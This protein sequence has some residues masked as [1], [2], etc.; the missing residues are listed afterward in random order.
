MSEAATTRWTRR[1][2]GCAALTVAAFVQAPRWTSADT[3]LDLLVDPTRFLGRALTLWEPLGAFGQLQNQAYGYL[4]PMGPFFALGHLLGLPVWVVQR[5]WWACLLVTAFLGLVLLAER[6]D[7]G[8]EGSRILAGLAFALSPRVLTELGGIS[9]ELW[10]TAVAPWVVLPLIGVPPGAERRAAARSGLAVALAGGVNAIAAGAV[11]PLAV[12]W[13]AQV[14]RGRARRRLATW[15][16]L[17]AAAGIGWWLGPLVLLGRYSPPFLDWIESAAVTTS[18]AGPGNALRGVSHWVGWLRGSAAVWPA[19]SQVAGSP[20]LIVLGWCVVALGLAAFFHR[21]TP[22]RTFLVGG[23]VI[24]LA[25]LTMGHVQPGGAPWAGLIRDLLDGPGA[26]L[27]NTHK[28]DVL[29]RL[30][31]SL[32]LAHTVA[33]V[34]LRPPRW[35]PWSRH[36]VR[37]VAISGVLGCAAPVLAGNLAARSPF[38]EI[39]PYWRQAAA[40][41]TAHDDGGRTLVLPGSSF[42]TNYWGDT[43]DEPLQALATTPWAARTVVPLSEPGAIRMLTTV[44]AQLATGRPSPGLADYLARAGISRLLVRADLAGNNGPPIRPLT[45]RS[46]LS[47]SP[48]LLPIARFGP[49]IG[50]ARLGTAVVDSGLDLATPAIEIWQVVGTRAAAEVWPA[51]AVAR[52]AGGVE[53]LLALA[54]AGALHRRPTVLDGDPLAGPLASGPVIVTDGPQRREADFSRVREVYSAPLGP[55]TPWRTR[56]A[57]HDWIPFAQPQVVADFGPLGDLSASSEADAAHSA[58]AALDGDPQTGW[59]TSVLQQ[60]LP[61]ISLT[62]PAARALP[63]SLQFAPGDGVGIAQVDVVTEQGRRRTRLPTTDDP[64]GTRFEVAIPPGQTRWLRVEFTGLRPRPGQSLMVR[65][66]A[67][68]GLVVPRPLRVPPVSDARSLAVLRVARSGTD[69]CAFLGGRPLCAPQLA[70][71]AEE[72]ALRRTLTLATPWSVDVRGT[73][74]PKATAALDELLA[75][76]GDAVLATSGSRRSDEPAERPQAAVDRDLGTAWVAAPGDAQPTLTL[77]W[78]SSRQIAELQLQTDAA[79]A[80]SRATQLTITAGQQVRTVAV[81]V[82][83]WARF[84]AVRA[85]RLQ[86]TV[87]GT[88]P[89]LSWDGDGR[90]RTLPFGVSEIVVPALHDL[91]RGPERAAASGAACGFGPAIVLGGRA[92][93]TRVVGTV[94][95]VEQ[96]RPLQLVPCT[97]PGVTLPVGEVA[98]AVEQTELW[99]PDTLVLGAADHDPDQLE[100]TA[101]TVGRWQAEHRVVQVPALPYD[102]VLVVHENLNRGWRAEVAGRELRAVRVDGWQQAWLVPAGVG[103]TVRL[104]FVPGTTYR[105]ALGLGAVLLVLLLA[106][107]M[108]WP[109]RTG[110]RHHG[111]LPGPAGETEPVLVW[112]LTSTALVI[113]AGPVAVGGAAI[114]MLLRRVG[115]LSRLQRVGLVLATLTATASAAV[116]TA[117]AGRAAAGSARLVCDVAVWVVMT[118]A[119]VGVIG[120]GSPAAGGEG[121]EAT[122][123]SGDDA[124]QPASDGSFDEV[125]GPG[126]GDEGQPRDADQQRQEMPGEGLDTPPFPDGGQHDHVPQEEAVADGSGPHQ[127]PAAQ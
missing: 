66:L 62:F 42:A 107:A 95:D 48:G 53:D 98:V 47:G 125:P 30:P 40:W 8:T 96:R 27:R 15:W 34:R 45:V 120:V 87:T 80:V 58:W 101:A 70:R 75:P 118:A 19:A 1:L 86:I 91:I 20:Q 88:R 51:A 108:P 32:G 52:V 99:Q 65:E 92:L 63:A 13:L 2:A 112:V 102:R 110:D 18:M 29:L 113:G 122:V 7:I 24:G 9:V 43:R 6:L 25:A 103:G 31:L 10:P 35:A 67:I 17:A 116:S 64:F 71:P 50:G 114:L 54:D 83:G 37:W 28:F 21:S 60:G 78:G 12:V 100:P 44:E 59:A 14:P 11:L 111:A 41:L 90:V 4:L 74:R 126:G 76:L 72:S 73:V 94:A 109:G 81:G 26:A 56:R 82:D 85:R 115:G 16:A 46:A 55:Q 39:P 5:C 117:F 77:D 38:A 119:T 49:D 106:A 121:R 3:K 79:L 68:D 89:Q 123:G 105:W 36:A 33:A 97:L 23:A 93:P 22:H 61:W 57:A 69:G 127:G 84:R 124:A 104:D